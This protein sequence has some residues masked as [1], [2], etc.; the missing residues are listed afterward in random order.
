MATIVSLVQDTKTMCTVPE[1]IRTN[2]QSLFEKY[3][4]DPKSI[5]FMFDNG[6][7]E[8]SS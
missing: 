8:H 6:K 5:P 3:Q 1:A 7:W 2:Y 4:Q